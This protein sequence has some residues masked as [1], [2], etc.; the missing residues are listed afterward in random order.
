[1]NRAGQR[2][3]KA[4]NVAHGTAT[5]PTWTALALLCAAQFVVVLNFQVGSIALPAIG[6]GLALS[7]GGLQW[8]VSANAL[9]FGGTLLLGGRLADLYGHRRLFM[10]GLAI[11]AVASLACGLAP[12]PAVLIA[13]RAAQGLGTA[14]ATPAA[15]ALL[16]DAYPE[17]EARNRALGIWGAAG[18]VGGIAGLLLGG[19]LAD[20]LGWRWVFFPGVPVAALIVALAPR[21]LAERHERRAS[22]RL[23]LAGALTGTG[24]IV[25]LVY[26]LSAVSRSGFAAAGV[27]LPLA[28]ATGLLLIF[29]RVEGRVAHPLVPLGILR[30]RD[31]I[32]ANLVAFLHAASTNTPAF[33]FTLYM[34]DVRGHALLLTGLAFLPCN[35][36]VIAGAALGTRLA[37][38]G[39]YR[40]A[41]ATGMAIVVVGLAALARI[42]VAGAYPT[43]LLPGLL[44]WGFGLGV[45]QVGLIGAS[46]AGTAESERG[47]AAGLLNTAAQLGTAVGLAI[48][49]SV[50]TA[51][52]AAL[53]GAAPGD[54][55]TV[56][57][58][59]WAFLAGGGIAALGLL[60][61]LVAARGH[62]PQ[63]D[64]LDAPGGEVVGHSSNEGETNAP[65]LS[66]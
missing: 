26:G 31:R 8:V 64:N 27:L 59:R 10:L 52:T 9:A 28:I 22:T 49:V 40:L 32:G 35:L 38:R 17:G 58:F 34:Q 65:P 41:M 36:A 14:L 45:A 62:K 44:L 66:A 39:G 29:L 1:M 12:L 63:R 46:T 16:T 48:L 21:A 24:A 18:P 43:T 6:R 5:P 13:A 56:A 50:A 25:A 20:S 53:G 47:A 19:L 42:A 11:F 54:A 3:T 23:D 30:D 33:F 7:P 2:A 4:R 55:A 57:G 60:A 61:A 51:R 15:L 37:D